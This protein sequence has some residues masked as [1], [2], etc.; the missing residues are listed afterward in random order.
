MS[1][2]EWSVPETEVLAAAAEMLESDREAVLATV[3]GVEGS[4]YRRPGAKMVLPEDGGGVGSITAG[5]LEDEVLALAQDVLASG[6]PRVETFDLTGDDDV[7][8]LGVGCNGVITIL[9]EPLDESYGPALDAHEAGNAIATCTVLDSEAPDVTAGGRAYYREGFEAQT[10]EWPDWLTDAL[11]EAAAALAGE[12]KAETLDFRGVSVFVD[13]LAPPPE[14]YVF[15]TGHDVGP[16]VE[17]AKKADFRVTVVGFRG[18][19]AKRDRFPKADD[20]VSTSPA[21]VRE[22]LDLHEDAYAVLMTHNFIDDRLALDELVKSSLEYVGLMGP[23][24]RFE[25]MQEDF[26]EEG[27]SFSDAELEKIYTPAG[28]D[29]GGGTPYQI[30]FSIVSEVLTVHN[31]RTPRH[32]KA[33]EG[34]IHDR[35][36]LEATADD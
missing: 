17:L 18:A 31:D 21:D 35:L 4:A 36:E 22:A 24:K 12:G 15:G 8:G 19:N 33:R 30:A 13:G 16:V 6:T 5:C 10:G 7:W 23:R 1:A 25:E 28:L 34:P 29:L 3:I 9:L 26:A 14:L 11:E 2:S 20:V 27:R 32:L